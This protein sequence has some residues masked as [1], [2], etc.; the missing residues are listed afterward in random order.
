MVDKAQFVT[1]TPSGELKMAE[2]PMPIG[3]IDDRVRAI[4]KIQQDQTLVMQALNAR[5]EKLEELAKAAQSIAEKMQK[6]PMK[7]V[8]G[9]L[10]GS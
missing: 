5:V 8:L 7:G 6:S 1:G 9:S 2:L 4:E 10:F 3:A